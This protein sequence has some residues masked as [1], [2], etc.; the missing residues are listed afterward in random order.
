MSL[1]DCSWLDVLEKV[2]FFPVWMEIDWLD[3]TA[4]FC[5]ILRTFVNKATSG[6][7]HV[8]HVK[9]ELKAALTL[10]AY[11]RVYTHVAY[12]APVAA[13]VRTIIYM[14]IAIITYSVRQKKYPL[15]FFAIFS[16][17][18][19]NFYMKFHRFIVHS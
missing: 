1:V 15:K 2:M 18:A 16:A 14:L 8:N 5:W 3:V 12:C 11:T 10:R 17:T 4:V 19:R 7:E 6:D 13:V 9:V